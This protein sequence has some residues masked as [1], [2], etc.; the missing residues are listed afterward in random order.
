MVEDSEQVYASQVLA[1]IPRETTKTKDPHDMLSVLGEKA[2]HA[3][4]VNE[5]Q[6][7]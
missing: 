6:E 1:K 3:H 4:L 7:V 2:L 5:I